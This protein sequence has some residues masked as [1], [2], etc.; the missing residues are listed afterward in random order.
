MR[1]AWRLLLVSILLGLVWMGLILSEWL[2]RPTTADVE[3]LAALQPPSDNV[4]GERNAF[5]LF[6]LFDYAVPE[7]ELNKVAAVDVAAFAA[8]ARDGGI[9]EFKVSAE[10]QYPML[11]QPPRKDPALCSHW[12]S[13]CLDLV[14]A[15][16][17]AARERLVE[18]APLLER[19]RLIRNYD[20]YHYQFLPRFDSP[21][22]AP[23]AVFG[24]QMTAVATD[25]LDGHVDAAFGH[26]CADTAAWRRIRAHADML[27][28]DMLGIGQVSGAA[29]LY[30]EMLAGQA[31]DFVPPCPEVFAPLEDAELDFCAVMRFEHLSTVNSLQDDA[32]R[33]QAFSG[34]A[35]GKLLRPLVNW[36]RVPYLSG[37]LLAG[38]C[39]APQRER[40]VRRD[41]APL[42]SVLPCTSMERV[43]DPVGCFL[44]ESAFPDYDPYFRRGLDLDARLRLV[45]AAI[46]LRA[47]P[48]GTDLQT[49]FA[50]RPSTADSPAHQFSLDLER[51]TLRM[52]NLEAATDGLA[53]RG[54]FWQIPIRLEPAAAPPVAVDNPN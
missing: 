1:T 6:W 14:R 52:R 18:F 39:Q 15:N 5:A 13:G 35:A 9:S 20:Y 2:P 42:A 41:P 26:L 43:F 11:P 23:S 24:L 16:R 10:G 7:S 38:Y 53:Q 3:A 25:Y 54:E 4:A 19:G 12:T 50:A 37:R 34:F 46:W 31:A 21:L 32:M 40:R 28:I 36:R 22:G 49:A 17:D 47:Q 30:A 27:I 51:A 33:V 29:Q 45:Q 44:A 8:A 48:A